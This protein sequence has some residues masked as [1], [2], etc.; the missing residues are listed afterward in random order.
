MGGARN[1]L[2]K[3]PTE[4]SR[5]LRLKEVSTGFQLSSY[6]VIGDNEES[7]SRIE[8]IFLKQLQPAFKKKFR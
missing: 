3:S 8:D 2:R 7:V 6:L 5:R 4:K 1:Q